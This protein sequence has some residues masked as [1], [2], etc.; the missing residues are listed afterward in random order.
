MENK[1][2]VGLR[3][4]AFI[5]DTFIVLTFW[6]VL[7]LMVV[8]AKT[9][10]RLLDSLLGAII[11]AIFFNLIW[12]FF[13]SLLISNLGGTIGKILTGTKII[14]PKGEKISFW[15]AFFRNQIGYPIS[16]MF[17]GLG[18]IWIAVD[19]ERRGWHDQAADTF[20]VVKKKGSLIMG[21][22]VFFFLL[23]LNVFLIIQNYS[24]FTKT[25]ELYSQTLSRPQ[26][27]NQLQTP[28]LEY[29]NEPQSATGKLELGFEN[30]PQ[31]FNIENQ[32][33]LRLP[34]L[35]KK[36]IPPL[37]FLTQSG[38]WFRAK[39]GRIYR[40][41]KN[42]NPNIISYENLFWVDK[43]RFL[44]ITELS[45]RE[46]HN[47][48]SEC[49]FSYKKEADIPSLITCNKFLVGK[50][51]LWGISLSPDKKNISFL[52]KIL[53]N[54]VKEDRVILT[55][56][57][58]SLNLI[59]KQQKTLG[60]ITHDAIGCGGGGFRPAS[61]LG[62]LWEHKKFSSLWTPRLLALT[63]SCEMD[64]MA[65][66]DMDSRTFIENLEG[67]VAANLGL[68]K[69]VDFY[70]TDGYSIYSIHREASGSLNKKTIFTIPPQRNDYTESDYISDIL[71]N[72]TQDNYI[73]FA[74][75]DRDK[76]SEY[77]PKD[78]KP[79]LATKIVRLDLKT[80]KP[81]VLYEENDA[82]FIGNLDSFEKYSENGEKKLYLT[83][84]KVVNAR[85][86]IDVQGIKNETIN[87][88]YNDTESIDLL[89]VGIIYDP[90]LKTEIG[91][92]PGAK[93]LKTQ[94]LN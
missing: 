77:T 28:K 3:L 4:L 70:Y 1:A 72:E 25:I 76:E 79:H 63:T 35:E 91:E 18:F 85:S 2:S 84:G 6:Q 71:T 82:W 14:N 58:R 10:E 61:L 51:Y 47:E 67:V 41:I 60:T 38:V 86:Y 31:S 65:V 9:I 80:H 27:E 23:V 93:I 81:E 87:M 15:R 37:I 24:L 52:G 20:V 92:I 40:I 36:E 7:L 13:N 11:I 32:E 33:Q 30:Q 66:F 26:Y 59:D 55:E 8:S 90:E 64:E 42:E 44:L 75:L 22:V 88:S 48:L 54:D 83:F 49:V 73:Y 46:Y 50:S 68:E 34:A 56:E 94:P 21:S 17:L 74:L 5:I 45:E 29:E 62:Y 53:N 57:V 19:K 16:G 39:D 89:P 78:K 69:D 12:P 43:N